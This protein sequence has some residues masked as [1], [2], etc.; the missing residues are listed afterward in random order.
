MR[1]RTITE[2]QNKITVDNCRYTVSYGAD[3]AVFKF[4]SDNF[5]N[6]VVCSRVN[7]GRRLIK[8]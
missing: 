8:H 6:K 2:D 5:L 1:L 4:C 3:G 7:R